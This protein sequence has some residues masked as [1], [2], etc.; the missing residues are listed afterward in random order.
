MP[1]LEQYQL[2]VVAVDSL[3]GPL[4]GPRKQGIQGSFVR[5]TERSFALIVLGLS[6]EQ[7]GRVLLRERE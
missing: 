1:P 5:D 2:G 4:P 6:G 3:G 7:K